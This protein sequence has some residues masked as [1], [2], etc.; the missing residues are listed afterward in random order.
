ML[1]MLARQSSGCPPATRDPARHRGLG[2]RRPPG[3]PGPPRRV[4]GP[5]GVTE[6]ATLLQS[7]KTSPRQG[8]KARA[9]W[10]WLACAQG[11]GWRGDPG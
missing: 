5:V 4:W 1:G 3:G 8:E 2:E 7:F 10:A 11:P 9:S 6:D